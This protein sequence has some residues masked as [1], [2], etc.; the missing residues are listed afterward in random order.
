MR[1]RKRGGPKA[2][3]PGTIDADLAAVSPDIRAALQRLRKAIHA[4]APAAGEC[5]SYGIPGF[6]Y[7]GWLVGFG[8]AASHCDRPRP[9]PTVGYA[10]CRTMSD[11]PLVS[12]PLTLKRAPSVCRRLL[13]RT[14]RSSMSHVRFIA[15]SA[16][17]TCALMLF[18][19]CSKTSTGPATYS[20]SYHLAGSASVAFDSVKYEDAQGTLV[21]VLAPARDWS[22]A[23]AENGGGYVT[24]SAWGTAS[25]GGQ[26]A[27]LKVIWTQ[28]G[29]STASD[30]SVAAISAPGTFALA[31][32]RRQI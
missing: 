5:I 14:D 8:A 30:S 17:V 26:T 12:I 9:W 15:P 23:F 20:V 7:H 4:A 21:R 18:A 28:S 13:Q 29:V 11:L 31:I 27:T 10:R 3:R 25:A 16:F 19:A 6:R 24:A 2:A 22:V 1:A 32:A